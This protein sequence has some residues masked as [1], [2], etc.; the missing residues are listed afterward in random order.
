MT[1]LIEI[2]GSKSSMLSLNFTKQMHNCFTQS[3]TFTLA[4]LFGTWKG[5]YVNTFKKLLTENSIGTLSNN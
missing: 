3:G 2:G 5:S 4:G 1:F